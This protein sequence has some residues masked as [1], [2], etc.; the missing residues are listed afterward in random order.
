MF[1]DD[2]LLL[3]VNVFILISYRL[4]CTKIRIM[5]R[6][7]AM[8]IWSLPEIRQENTDEQIKFTE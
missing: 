1:K 2:M 7:W 4:D 6:S 8:L 3:A 5:A